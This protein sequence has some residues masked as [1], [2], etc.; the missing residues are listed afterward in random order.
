MQQNSTLKPTDRGT[1]DPSDRTN[2]VDKDKD[3]GVD[4]NQ[5]ISEELSMCA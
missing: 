4:F 5:S 2:L 1:S 3:D